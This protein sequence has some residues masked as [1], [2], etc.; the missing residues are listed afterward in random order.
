MTA[1]TDRLRA[2]LATGRETSV[3]NAF[4]NILKQQG[5]RGFWSSNLANVV[6]VAPENGIAFLLNDVMRDRVCVDASAPTVSE[7][8]LLGSAAGAIAM[9]AVYPM[10][11]VQNRM[12]AARPGQY[13]GMFDCIR[14]VGR[15]GLGSCYAGYQTSL[16]R[17]I[18]MKGI[19]LGGYSTL[20]DMAK[21]Q[22]TGEI[23]TA[24]SLACSATSGG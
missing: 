7:R 20:K 24:M 4:N 12:A 8:F 1:P 13:R 18:P 21:D 2:V 11:V 6:Q 19:M 16:V 14:E 23:S 10:Y 5:V 15:G 9:T 3:A 17:V 22:K